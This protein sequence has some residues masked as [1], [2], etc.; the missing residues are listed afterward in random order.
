[1]PRREH[2]YR[3]SRVSAVHDP[4]NLGRAK[5]EPTEKVVT[6]TSG[7][8]QCTRSPCFAEIAE[9]GDGTVGTEFKVLNVA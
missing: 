8:T 4:L 7:R 3:P 1:M 9:P 5:I 6:G 2:Q